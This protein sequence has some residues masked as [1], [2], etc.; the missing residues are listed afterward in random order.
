MKQILWALAIAI[1]PGMVV[2]A[3]PAPS[4]APSA[5]WPAP[6]TLATVRPARAAQPS[7]SPRSAQELHAAAIALMQQG[8][9]AKAR[10]PLEQAYDQTPP[11]Q[12]ARPLILNRAIVDV[13]MK[14]NAMRA[15]RELSDYLRA[16]R[17]ADVMATDIFGAALNLGANN[18]KVKAGPLWQSAFKEWDRRNYELEH[19]RPGY[20]RFGAKWIDEQDYLDLQAQYASQNAIA[21]QHEAM[22]RA[23]WNYYATWQRA[24]VAVDAANYALGGE[25]DDTN[26]ST[27]DRLRGRARA[28]HPDA[29]LD[30]PILKAKGQLAAAQGNVLPQGPLPDGA[31]PLSPVAG[32]R[33]PINI[34]EPGLPKLPAPTPLETLAPLPNA[35]A[36]PTELVIKAYEEYG[37]AQGDYNRE[38]S[39]Y[40][41]LLNSRP[42]PDWPTRFDP[43][44]IS[45]LTAPPIPPPDPKAAAK[46]AKEKAEDGR[47]GWQAAFGDTTA[48]PL[49]PTS[50]P[51]PAPA[52][53]QGGNV[54]A[55]TQPTG[56]AQPLSDQQQQA[57]QRLQ[58]PLAPGT[59]WPAR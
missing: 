15:V 47:T 2:A 35:P 44:A 22:T 12:R 1:G 40:N 26:L 38:V 50:G 29:Q 16:R 37:V 23:W 55:A 32:S 36:A 18:P 14:T 3:T 43:V 6:S 30:D 57:Q 27:A 48:P 54:P 39:E 8:Q 33:Q 52:T 11:A 45:E 21:A 53:V 49:G 31:T 34:T 58:Q 7:S 13:A 24:K 17:D 59:S 51:A 56:D 25:M 20:H 5:L 19:A 46:E 4:T 42:K 41:R 9:F 28:G 10:V